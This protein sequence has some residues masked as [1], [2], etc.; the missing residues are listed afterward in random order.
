MKRLILMRHAKSDWSGSGTS[1]HDRT[2]NARGRRDAP[3]LGNWLR[4]QGLAPDEVLCSTSTRTRETLDLL[5]LGGKPTVHFNR[6]LYLAEA[7]VIHRV[8]SSAR[9]KSVLLIGH[10]PGIGEVAGRIMDPETDIDWIGDYPT[11][12]T[13]VTTHQIDDWAKLSWGTGDVTH[14]VVPRALSSS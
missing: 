4:E 1:D 11:G 8:L 10:N 2:L 9:G 7:A 5:A 13:L 6:D 14:S 12:A 3:A